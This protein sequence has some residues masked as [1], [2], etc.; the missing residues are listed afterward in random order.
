MEQFPSLT[1][2]IV[3]VSGSTVL[4]V[5]VV[6]WA[7]IGWHRRRSIRQIEELSARV[8]SAQEAERA[9]LAAELHDDVV[10]RLFGTKMRLADTEPVA[11]EQL[12][13]LT[14]DLRAL[15]HHLRDA[16][17]PT[18]DL[19]SSLRAL[20]AGMFGD[21]ATVD[22]PAGVE[23]PGATAVALY[24]VAQESLTNV[25]KHAAASSVAVRL[26]SRGG[27]VVL[28]VEDDG[29][30]LSTEE[31]Y[32]EGFG[33]RSMRERMAA[34]GG[35]LRVGPGSGGRGTLVEASVVAR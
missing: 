35:S 27:T 15:A 10:P 22:V 13:E 9:A 2:W 1:A 21:R 20:A 11:M 23:L 7:F 28:Q 19:P 16:R 3:I 17:L 31:M 8:L 34:V 24:R 30:G 12:D 25:T 18:G 6:A 4:A 33:L 5:L 14:A 29:T 26:W 32:E